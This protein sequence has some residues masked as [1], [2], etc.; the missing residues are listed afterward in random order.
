MAEEIAILKIKGTGELKK[1]F[2]K[3]IDKAD[4]NT[5]I[6]L[7]RHPAAEEY[8]GVDYPLFYDKF[9]TAG[10]LLTTNQIVRGHEY[11]KAMDKGWL[12]GAAFL[13]DVRNFVQTLS[14]E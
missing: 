10:E 11:L 7:N 3:L 8:L 4:R 1:A 2:K 14:K 6:V 9:R 13:T 5:P 12:D